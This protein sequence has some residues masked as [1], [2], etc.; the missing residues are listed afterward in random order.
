MSYRLWGLDFFSSLLQCIVC[1]LCIS[2]LVESGLV[3]FQPMT[4]IQ[5]VVRIYIINIGVYLV[6]VYVL[7]R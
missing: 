4:S 5:G 1:L 6:L 7:I 3:L 2:C